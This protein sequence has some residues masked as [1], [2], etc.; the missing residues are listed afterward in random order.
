MTKG[1]VEKLQAT[2][3]IVIAKPSSSSKDED[4]AGNFMENEHESR[5]EDGRRGGIKVLMEMHVYGGRDME[6]IV[7]PGPYKEEREVIIPV[8]SKFHITKITG[9]ATNGYRIQ[10]L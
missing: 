6:S 9:N 7:M 10:A 2:K 3:V 4:V 5:I 1:Q 8:G